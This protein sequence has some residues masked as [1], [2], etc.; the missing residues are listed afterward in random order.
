MLEAAVLYTP[1][2]VFTIACPNF[3]TFKLEKKV[4]TNSQGSH[5]CGPGRGGWKATLS[6]IFGEADSQTRSSDT[7]LG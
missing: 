5:F 2:V 4:I 1:T 3:H 6:T 7:S